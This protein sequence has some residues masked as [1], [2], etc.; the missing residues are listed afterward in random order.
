MSDTHRGSQGQ[1]VARTLQGELE[2]T[3]S[4]VAL[5]QALTLRRG[6]TSVC[7]ARCVS[8]GQEEARCRCSTVAMAP[9]LPRE[10]MEGSF[11][12][13]HSGST[14]LGWWLAAMVTGIRAAL[15]RHSRCAISTFP[16]QCPGFP[17]ESRMPLGK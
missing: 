15:V 5:L 2:V 10:F 11:L 13:R 9:V 4:S 1:L 16:A 6:H 12:R 3:L 17:F 8:L 14:H 7:V